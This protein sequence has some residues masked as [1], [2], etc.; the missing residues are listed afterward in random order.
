ME[1]LTIAPAELLIDEENPR[2]ATPNAG[3]HRALQL[4]A[5]HLQQKLVKLASDIVK[6]GIDPSSLPIV[7][8]VAGNPQRYRVLEGNRRLAALR[9]LENPETVAETVTPAVLSSLRKLS[10]EYQGNP[11]ETLACV[12]VRDRDAARHWI[13][14]RHTGLN[15]GAGIMGWGSDEAARFR[16]RTR[17][18]EIHSQALDF[19]EKRGDL[20]V[21]DRRKVPVTTLKR[22]VETP[23]VRAKLGLGVHKGTLMLLADEA[24]VA[25]ALMHIISDLV[26]GK[27]RV[28][29]LYTKSQRQ[30]YARDL[31]RDVIVPPTTT[32]HG[33]AATE[34]AG[35]VHRKR[36]RQ[37]QPRRRDRLIPGDCVL[38][39][40][41]GRICDIEAELRKLSLEEHP[42]AVSVLFRVFLELSVDSYLTE[43]PQAGANI[44]S[45]LRVKVVKVAADLEARKKLDRQQAKAVRNT[46]T[47]QSFLAPNINTMHDYVHN[48]HIFP[49]PSDLRASWNNMQAL[50]VAMWT[51]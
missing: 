39:I 28:P 18:P 48:E 49:A 11:V 43:H 30:I 32:G 27:K 9:V 35:T 38:S 19:L 5:Q 15:E 21:D 1:R 51:P 20:S 25:R 44:D 36:P 8:P 46:A 4:L 2:I 37:A 13:E 14:L 7:M 12:A 6:H 31:P 22:L 42:N 34:A 45:K 29:D 23:D 3:Q 50:F 26:S 24:R 40:P 33:M 41:R 10:R 47:G 17:T 16:A